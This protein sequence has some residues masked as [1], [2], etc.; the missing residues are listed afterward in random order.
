MLPGLVGALGFGHVYVLVILVV[1]DVVI[2]VVVVLL[3]LVVV[4]IFLVFL[5]LLV[6][7]VVFGIVVV[8]GSI[9]VG[10]GQNRSCRTCS[11]QERLLH[12]CSDLF[13]DHCNWRS[14]LPTLLP[15]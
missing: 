2:V 10:L 7:L 4:L 14:V 11:P 9:L 15:A 13:S 8:V 3:F 12:T 5:A 1:V 6:V